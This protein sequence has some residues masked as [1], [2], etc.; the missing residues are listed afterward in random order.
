MTQH[1]WKYPGLPLKVAGDSLLDAVKRLMYEYRKALLQEN[2][3][4]CAVIDRAALDVPTLHMLIPAR[5]P[6]DEH[7]L[8]SDRDAAHLSD[9][10]P[11]TIRKWA[12]MGWINRY[13]DADG[14]RRYKLGEILD[15]K[16]AQR[17][18]RADRAG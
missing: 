3:D 9:L 11:A 6:Y 15:V 4:A 1:V 5:L 8:V 14:S 17:R 18:K 16:N 7:E 12:S 10:A 2:P 13:T